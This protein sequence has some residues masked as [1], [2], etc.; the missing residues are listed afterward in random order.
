MA[1]I[2]LL[3]N[4][5]IG[6]AVAGPGLRYIELAAALSKNHEVFLAAKSGLKINGNKFNILNTPF[7]LEI[8]L[9]IKIKIPNPSL[10]KELDKFDFVIAQEGVLI[11]LGFPKIRGKL[12]LDL[13][14]PAFLENLEAARYRQKGFDRKALA[15]FKH[16]IDHANFVLCA[17][18]KQRD[19]YTAL[20]LETRLFNFNAYAKDPSL[21]SLIDVVP[22][23]IS[24]SPPIHTKKA[25]KGA[26]PGIAVTDKVVIW[27]G[28]IWEW[29]D[30][31]TTIR[32]MAMASKVR[33]DLRLVFF[34]IKHPNLPLTVRAQKAV[35]LSKELGLYNKSVFFIQQWVPYN[36]RADYLLESDIGIISH[37][38]TLETHFSWRT[39]VL[40]Y[41]WADLPAITSTGD[42]MAEL[43]KANQLGKIVP[44]GNPD[45][46][47]QA[48]IELLENK[49][50]YREI[51]ENIKRFKPSL[52]WENVIAPLELFIS[53]QQS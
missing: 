16:A 36:E 26:L 41:F 14:C 46:L 12:I 48:I 19:F 20:L 34:G 22:V 30:P 24:S 1:R 33:K 38:Q 17:N 31:E 23:G 9:G 29:L 43:I 49:D 28:G 35:T 40:D 47:A 6:S 45:E 2:L 11:A 7:L 52:Y 37:R 42:S 8:N 25:L 39:R 15:S 21:R 44:P 53:Q 32:A 13:Y 4:D 51:K 10:I 27:W 18:E 5:V 50:E 3:S